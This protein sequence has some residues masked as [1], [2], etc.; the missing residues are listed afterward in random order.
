[1]KEK[2]KNCLQLACPN[3]NFENQDSLIDGGILDSLAV[4]NI[5]GA[6]TD[7]FGIEID[8]DDIIAENFNSVDAIALLVERLAN[9]HK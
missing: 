6:L 9:E 1:M 3:V 8:A 5:I 4:I 7:T 2:V